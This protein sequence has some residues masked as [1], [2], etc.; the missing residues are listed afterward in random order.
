M[1]ETV[2][3]VEPQSEAAARTLFE[4]REGRLLLNNLDA[5]LLDQVRP[6][7]GWRVLEV[8]CGHGNLTRLLLDRELVVAADADPAGVRVM[9]E[10]FGQYANVIPCV[11]DIT[12]PAA[13]ALR[14]YGCD[15]VISVNVLEH[16]ADDVTA[17]R[18]MHDLLTPGGHVIVVAPAHP[19]LYGPMDRAVGH[20]RRYTLGRLRTRIEQAG[21]EPVALHYTNALGALGWWVNGR[22][23]RQHGP[24]RA[25]LRM[26]N[27]LTPLLRWIESRVRPPFGLS[28]VSVS[29][30]D[31]M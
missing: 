28:V 26:F 6:Y 3:V 25:Q 7:I 29:Q 10:R 20:Y 23:L 24:N 17:L 18:Y 2:K 19:W 1:A 16:I 5:W 4:A 31:G 12:D 27:R 30:K 9:R 22:V 15:T 8:G 13:L 11:A 21:A 14:D